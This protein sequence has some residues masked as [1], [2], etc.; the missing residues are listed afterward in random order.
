MI[1]NK[2]FKNKKGATAVE[3]ALVFG[4]VMLLVF[5]I[6]ELGLLYAAAAML[7]GGTSE[8]ARLIRTGQA[9][10]SGDPQGVFEAELCSN[11]SIFVECD[12]LISE[13]VLIPDQDFRNADDVDAQYDADGNLIPRGFDP[14]GPNDVILVRT[15]YQYPFITPLV[16][17]FVDGGV[18]SSR[19]LQATIVLR[20]EP[21][22]F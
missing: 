8:A 10:A 1:L 16:S 9:Q 14:G 20:N 3:F 7:E 17:A 19:T 18:G 4:P 22:E 2:W 11:V 12:D 5:G 13:V 15:F 21:Y 6:I